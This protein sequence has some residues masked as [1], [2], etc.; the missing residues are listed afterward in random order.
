MQPGHQGGDIR[1]EAAIH[2]HRAFAAQQHGIGARERALEDR[3]GRIAGQAD[4]GSAMS[5]SDLPS[6]SMPSQTSI[7]APASISTPATP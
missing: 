1:A 6:A 7:A 2:Q 5:S 3:E 4:S